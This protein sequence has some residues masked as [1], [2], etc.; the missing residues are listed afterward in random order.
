M[1]TQQRRA[2][3]NDFEFAFEAKKQALGP[4]IKSKWEWD[5]NYQ[6]TVH[7]KRW[8]EKTWYILL[9]HGSRIGTL[10]ID[11]QE[12]YIRFGEFYLLDRYRNQGIGTAILQRFLADSDQKSKKVVL[13]YLKW[14]PVGKLYKRNGFTVIGKSEIHYFM[15]RSPKPQ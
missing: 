11:E 10:S 14:N 8:V 9:L 5:E 2:T 4:H 3:E 1:K 13:E 12:K 15:E 6:L 7:R